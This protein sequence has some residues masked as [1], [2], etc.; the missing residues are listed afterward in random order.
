MKD[1]QEEPSQYI[2]KGIPKKSINSREDKST[3]NRVSKL[4]EKPNIIFI[5]DLKKKVGPNRYKKISKNK[6]PEGKKS[7][8][9]EKKSISETKNIEPGKPKKIRIFNSIERNN[10]GHRKLTPLISVIKR[11]LNLL[12]T[13]STSKKELV[14]IKAW[15]ISMQKLANIKFDWP[16]ITQ[17]VNQCISTTVE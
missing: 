8:K 12:A 6:A 15:L 10:L 3:G 13:A 16:L 4:D 1:C 11:V 2:M 5:Q 9:K 17:I 7:R 14:E